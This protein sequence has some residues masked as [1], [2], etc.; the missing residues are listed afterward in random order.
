M[1]IDVVQRLFADGA[2]HRGIDLHFFEDSFDDFLVCFQVNGLLADLASMQVLHSQVQTRLNDF[3]S[4]FFTRLLGDYHFE[5]R[6]ECL[7][8]L[9]ARY[10]WGPIFAQCE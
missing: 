1:H 6:N 8:G 3:L 4:L 2:E 5:E 10:K 9:S 7:S